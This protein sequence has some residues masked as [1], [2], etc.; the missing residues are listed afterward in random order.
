MDNWHPIH[1]RHAIEVMAARVTFTEA[2][3][4]LPYR[5]FISEAEEAAFA[6]G[7]RSR[8]SVA[9]TT[10]MMGPQGI[11]LPA[12]TD[13]GGGRIFNSVFEEGAAPSLPAKVREQVQIDPTS[14][15]YR[16]WDYQSWSHHAD[17]IRAL[18]E[19]PLAIAD[20]LAMIATVR[21]EYLNQF[22]GPEGSVSCAADELLKP[23]SSWIA[24][25]I[26]HEVDLWHSHTGCFL[27]VAGASKRLQ[28][29]NIDSLELPLPPDSLVSRRSINVWAALEDRFDSDPSSENACVH[30][31][32][33]LDRFGSI[34]DSLKNLLSQVLSDS[35]MTAISFWPGK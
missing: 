35:A 9:A 1:G 19:K 11:V 20:G 18:L 10:F 32:A 30:T 28:T 16:T 26:F 6:N 4:E 15:T 24:P 14:I 13:V 5:R 17:R 33:G 29:L 31:T 8:H 3:P 12:P 21:L 22:R 7:L 25:H 23:N 34:H 27:P 2:L